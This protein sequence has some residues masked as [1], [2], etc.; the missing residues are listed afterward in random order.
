MMQMALK[1]LAYYFKNTKEI[2]VISFLF[3]SIVLLAV[4]AYPAGASMPEAVPALVMWLALASAIQLGAAQSWQ[5]HHDNGEI[6]LFQLLPWLMEWSVLGKY[7]GFVLMLWLQLLWVV[8]LGCMWLGWPVGQWG[9]AA[10]G[11]MAGTAALAAIHLQSAGLMVGSRKS[12]H[13]LGL[14]SLPF[15]VPILIFGSEYLRQP[16]LWHGSLGFMLGYT[17]LLV[18]CMAVSVAAHLRHSH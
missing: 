8:P 16:A 4:F 3:L 13:L 14:V 11:L 1:E 18:P 15:A 10:I 17:A 6:E 12:G 2:I 7:V 5:R 9:Q